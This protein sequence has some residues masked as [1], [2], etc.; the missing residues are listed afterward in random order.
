MKKA[1]AGSVPGAAPAPHLFH[2]E[3][4]GHGRAAA[5]ESH[6]IEGTEDVRRAL[7]HIDANGE[8]GL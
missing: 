6:A 3:G 5:G 8:A 1:S 2:R 4:Q 7:G